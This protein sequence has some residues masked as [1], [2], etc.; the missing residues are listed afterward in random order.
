MGASYRA[1]PPDRLLSEPGYRELGRDTPVGS[2]F[3]DP[4]DEP[5]GSPDTT[6]YFGGSE[7]FEDDP[8]EDCSIDAPS[9]TDESLLAQAAPAIA[10]ESPPVLSPPIAPYRPRKIV[11]GPRKTVQPQTPLPPSI[12]VRIDDWIAAYLSSPPPSPARSGPSR[13]R[14]RSSPLSSSGPPPKR[15]R[16]SL[17]P[18]LPSSALHYVPTKLLPPRKRFTALERIETLE[19]EVESLTTRLAAAMIQIDALQR[20]DIG[21][22]VREVRIEARLKRVKDTMQRR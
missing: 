10:F 14:P 8:S 21:R 5:L 7:F 4:D 1:R 2:A 12:L 3:L 13:M 11:Q 18:A 9:G 6:D 15:S 19:R 20:D 16:V 22:D 17:A